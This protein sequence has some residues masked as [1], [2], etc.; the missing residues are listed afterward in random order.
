[1]KLENIPAAMNGWK[2]YCSYRNKYGTTNT[3]KATL[4]VISSAAASSA[5][6]P[7]PTPTP[8][9]SGTLLDLL[10]PDQLEIHLN[11]IGDG[12]EVLSEVPLTKEESGLYSVRLIMGNN[13]QFTIDVP[14]SGIQLLEN[15][16][17]TQAIGYTNQTVPF[18]INLDLEKSWISVDLSNN[19]NPGGYWLYLDDKE[20]GKKI[21]KIMVLWGSVE[22][23]APE[24]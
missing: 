22:E 20:T 2:V 23:P 14:S 3:E 15:L 12:D 7:T 19:K 17:V 4:T 5:P 10:N 21:M 24:L 16:Q 11:E 18:E 1:M 8:T 6:M 9:P 13:Y